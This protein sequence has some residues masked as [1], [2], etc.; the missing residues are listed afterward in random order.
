MHSASREA[1]RQASQLVDDHV[2]AQEN[3]VASAA[4]IGSELF[5]VVSVFDGDRGLRVAVADTTVPAEHRAALVADLFTGKVS[6]AAVDVAASVLTLTWSS[7]RDMRDGLARAA[8]R[9][10]FRSAEE[11]GQLGRVEDELFRLSRILE[12]EPELTQ[13]LGD[14][15]QPADRKRD[16]LARV[17]Y[18]K[19]TAVTEAVALQ[20]IS[21]PERNPI[22]DITTLTTEAAET[23]GRTV[24]DVV[25]AIELTDVQEESL[26]R[27]LERIY[28]QTMSIHTEVDPSLL[29]GAIIRVGDEVIDGSVIGKLNKLRRHCAR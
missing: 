20:V 28:G 14:R 15:S 21:R 27:K 25:S 11:Q 23:R 17:L 3:S 7:T 8:R 4:Q 29:G 2:Q 5:D 16:L 13:L 22:D 12:Q 6:A 9:F 1:W 10:L 19:V 26:A 24:A 18:G